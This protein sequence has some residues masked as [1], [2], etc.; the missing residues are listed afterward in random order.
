MFNETLIES[1]GH[2]QNGKRLL[3]VQLAAIV[4]AAIVGVLIAGSFWYVDRMSLPEPDKISAVLYEKIPGGPPPEFG[5]RQ[6]QSS[7]ILV[8]FKI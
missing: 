1:M 4:H 8:P 2:H 7:L 6:K 3:T 5:V